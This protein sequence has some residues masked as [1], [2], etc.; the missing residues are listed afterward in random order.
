VSILPPLDPAVV[1][2]DSVGV[3]VI[4]FRWNAVPGAAGYQVSTDGGTNFTNPSSGSTGLSHMVVGLQ[5]AQQVTLIVKAIGTI[6]CQESISDAVSG[7]TLVDDIFIPNT[8][9]PNGDGLNDVFRV[10]GN[11]IREMNLMVFN[12]WGEKVFQSRDVN[13][14]WDGRYAG[15]PQPSGVYIV[16][17]QI[18]LLDGTT[19]KRNASLN[20]IR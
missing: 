17:A 14:G 12:Q 15:K 8:F 16:V 19:I 5:P 3:N 1:V 9:T 13:V 10:Y 7:R 11:I 20:L 6:T 4:R 18:T 2:V